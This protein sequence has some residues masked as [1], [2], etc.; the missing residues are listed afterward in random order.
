M[1]QTVVT[2]IGCTL[3]CSSRHE[4]SPID[5]QFV[6][7]ARPNGEK[8]STSVHA[9]RHEVAR[10]DQQFSMRGL[11]DPSPDMISRSTVYLPY[12]PVL[13]INERS[14]ASIIPADQKGILEM[15]LCTLNNH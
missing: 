6:R 13:Y 2:F 5:Q 10:I 7:S 14:S 15:R 4:A 3:L 11:R 9:R 12:S 8:W 1:R